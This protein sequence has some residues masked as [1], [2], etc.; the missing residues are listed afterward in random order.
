MIARYSRPEMARV[1][2]DERRLALWL[3][4]ELA[5]TAA[6]ETHG[7]AP[8]GVSERLRRAVRVDA[9][10][11]E[12]IEHEVRHDVIAFLT[13]VAESGGDDARELHV[14]MTS[15]DLVDTALACQIAE[16]GRVLRGPVAATR[17]AAWDLA[18]R[19]RR[20]P[21]I[22]RTHGIHA[23]P[24]TFG[25]K[26]LLWSEE[27]GRDQ[28]RLERALEDAA[29]GKVS[30]AVGTLAHLEPE[31]ERLALQRLG[32]TAEPV[33][34]QVVQ[35]DRHAALL[36]ALAVLGG[37]LEKIALE[38][39]HLQ[40]TEV[41]E[42]EEPF[43]E[44]QKGSSAM[45]HKRNPVQCERICGLSRLLRAYA[46]A[47]LENQ[48]LWHERDISH[49]SVERVILPDAFL[50]A[51][52]MADELGSVLRDLRVY[53]ENMRRNLDAGGGLVHSQRVLLALTHQGVPRDEAYRLVQKSALQALD[54]GGSFRAL[55][56]AEP[57]VRDT[58]GRE[59]LA[60]CFDLE[61]Y[62]RHVDDLFARA[63]PVTE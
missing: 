50:T 40:R 14:G 21:M 20:T 13:M 42:A 16:A 61:P 10:R 43:R 60:S 49:S 58:L 8:A 46:Q 63:H 39:R 24:I 56:E 34:N 2:S 32:L 22:G 30:G 33:A 26:C 6:R 48:A 45:P 27:L 44:G 17:R 15:S 7:A 25:L 55:L 41:R 3:E 53:P 18:Q 59:R 54:G 35:R 47:A 11:M 1:W 62:F 9:A 12:T 36:C 5:V 51:D 38:V 52:F 28:A 4:V 31:I 57:R 29:V 37:T 23:E 19:H